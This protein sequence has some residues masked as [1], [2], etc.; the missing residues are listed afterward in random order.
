M[1]T[2]TVE[3][4]VGVYLCE[5]GGNIGDVVDIEEIRKHVREWDHVAIARKDNYLCSKPAQDTIISDIEKYGLD[6]V[7]WAARATPKQ[8]K[9]IKGV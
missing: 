9:K 1:I 6:R 7:V 3:A 4:R 5:C 2:L 8:H